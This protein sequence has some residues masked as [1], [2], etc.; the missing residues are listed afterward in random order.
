MRWSPGDIQQLEA[1]IRSIRSATERL[2]AFV[3]FSALEERLELIE[4]PV[5]SLA[6]D[7]D[8]A[9]QLEADR[10]RGK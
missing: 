1:D 5:H 6:G 7:M 9:I 2:E 3:A 4:E 10:L 8:A